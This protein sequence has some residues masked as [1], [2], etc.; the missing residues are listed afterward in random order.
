M[1]EFLITFLSFFSVRLSEAC[2]VFVDI[3][4]RCGDL[5]HHAVNKRRDEE[6]EEL[7]SFEDELEDYNF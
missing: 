4:K 2:F 5:Q 1:H 7:E 3:D 6:L